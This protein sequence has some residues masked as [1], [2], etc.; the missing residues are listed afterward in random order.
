MD[1]QRNTALVLDCNRPPQAG[2]H[3]PGQR[4]HAEPLQRQPFHLVG[5][6][7]RATI[8]LGAPVDQVADDRSLECAR[9]A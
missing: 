5:H 3:R 8:E 1:N 9:I 2:A 4:V 7:L 6:L